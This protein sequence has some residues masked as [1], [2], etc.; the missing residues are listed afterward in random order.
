MSRSSATLQP[1]R[2]KLDGESFGMKDNAENTPRVIWKPP[3]VFRL[4]AALAQRLTWLIIA[5]I[6]G[7]GATVGYLLYNGPT[8]D[9]SALLMV[10]VGPELAAPATVAPTK[11]QTMMPIAKTIEDI[12]G[13]VQI[14][15]NPAIVEQAVEELGVDFFYGEDNAVTFLQKVKKAVKDAIKFIKEGVRGLLIKIGLL[16]ELTKL[17]MAT[18]LLQRNLSIEHV[19]RSDVIQLSIGYPDPYLGEAFLAKFIEIYLKQRAEVY[20]DDRIAGLF[21]RELNAIARELTSAEESYTM[22]SE[23][24]AGWSIEDQ[25]RMVVERRE[26]L[27]ADLDDAISTANVAKVKVAEI[28]SQLAGLPLLE[29]SSSSTARSNLF[30]QLR[31]KEIELVLELEAERNL[32]GIRSQRVQVLEQQLAQLQATLADVPTYVEDTNVKSVNPLRKSLEIQR[33][34]A[35]LLSEE[36]QKRIE[37]LGHRV[38]RVEAELR[39]I[40][41]AS[42][43]LARKTRQIERLRTSEIAFQEAMDDARITDLVSAASISNVVIISQ[44]QGSIAPV[45]PRVLRT[46]L[47]AIVFSIIAASGVILVIDAMRPKVR[48]NTDILAF[49]D[50]PTIVR[51]VS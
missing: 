32:S 51:A 49:T 18:V 9:I 3:D 33:A 7:L 17:E 5:P 34:D 20:D 11:N 10:R 40:D 6:I 2:K 28:D 41:R 30:D 47:I 4:L 14:M 24:N 45:K 16:P 23:E 25:R 31:F 48:S 22:L 8:Y 29:E 1:S 38:K 44:P 43:E 36:T 21:E 46:F 19:T 37:D 26:A 39:D 13:E 15:S 12:T 27:R 50:D 35:V 42:L